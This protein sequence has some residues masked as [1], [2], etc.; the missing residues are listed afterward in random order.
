M[1]ALLL[2]TRNE[3][4]LLRVNL[5][6]HLASGF[7]HVGVADHQSSDGTREVVESFGSGATYTLF[8]GSLGM[9][10]RHGAGNVARTRLF[11]LIED[12]RGPIEWA[13]VSDTDEFWWT[14]GGTVCD[15]VRGLPHGA[16]GVNFEQKL[17]LPTA[18]DR[19]EDV[20]YRR[21]IFRSSGPGSILHT[22]Y[23][24]GKSFYR[25][26]WLRR[27]GVASAHWDNRIGPRQRT[28][29]AALHHYM[30]QDEDQFVSKVAWF[31]EDEPPMWRRVESLLDPARR[32][33]H[34]PRRA[35]HRSM[36]GK[37]KHEWWKIYTAGGETALRRYYRDVYSLDANAVRMHITCGDLI[38]DEL[39][40]ESGRMSC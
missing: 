13:A 9:A 14:P 28:E 3:A 40:A 19:P 10:G 27:H 32:R 20:V 16:M 1:M 35:L 33:W 31:I 23:S 15:V 7:D 37:F 29:V 21:R 5:E 6:H 26:V 12:R 2:I 25:G 8:D 18:L 24:V 17:F 22:S 30:F 34:R 39:F 11:R 4:E 36:I 38:R